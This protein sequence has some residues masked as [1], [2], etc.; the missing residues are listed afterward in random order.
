MD[1]STG[2]A[3]HQ[4]RRGQG[5]NPVQAFLATTKIAALKT[6]W[7][8]HIKIRGSKIQISCINIIYI[9]LDVSIMKKK[10]VFLSFS[11][12][13]PASQHF[14]MFLFLEAILQ[15]YSSN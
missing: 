10:R 3:L 7:I 15:R 1:R 8:I 4:N 13:D 14:R 9:H 6:A 12:F 5:S 2:G 11:E